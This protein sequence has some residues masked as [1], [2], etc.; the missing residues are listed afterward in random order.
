M[1]NSILQLTT[2]DLFPPLRS[3]SR[4][5]LLCIQS[6]RKAQKTFI[7]GCTINYTGVY[8]QLYRR[9]ESVIQACRINYTSVYNQLYRRI[10]SR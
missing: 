4:G 7:Q 5:F 6:V 1:A 8:N 3:S 10:E 9:V 2:I